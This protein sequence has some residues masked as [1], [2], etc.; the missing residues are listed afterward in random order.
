MAGQGVVPALR[1]RE[2]RP[3][4][5]FYLDKLG[6]TVERG[7]PGDDNTAIARGD[8]R[9]MLETVEDMYSDGYNEAIR[10]RL[11]SVSAIAL[12]MEAPD[13]DALYENVRAAGVRVVDPLADRSWGQAEFTIEDPDGTWLTF[14]RSTADS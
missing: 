6:F 7:G 14:W 8:A 5:E 13:L 2:M 11:G 4:L 3:S 10:G 9:L 12:Y 1:V